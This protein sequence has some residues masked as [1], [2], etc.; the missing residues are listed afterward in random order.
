M[1]VHIIHTCQPAHQQATNQAAPQPYWLLG[2]WMAGDDHDGGGG[3]DHDDGGGGGVPPGSK[4]FQQVCFV[5]WPYQSL[6]VL[7]S[8]Q[9]QQACFV[10][11]PH[12]SLCAPERGH[13]PG[14]SFS[15][16]IL[17]NSLHW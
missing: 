14:S 8:K 13:R 17:Q 3:G 5:K 6:C 15:S 1:S 16:R 4:Q 12:Q 7:G 2:D 9:F 11:W 10:K